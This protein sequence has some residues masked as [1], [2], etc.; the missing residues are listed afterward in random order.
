MSLLPNKDV[1]AYFTREQYLSMNRSFLNKYLRSEKNGVYKEYDEVYITVDGIELNMYVLSKTISFNE[2]EHIVRWRK[3][4]W[5]L[6][7]SK[8]QKEIK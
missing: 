4:N 2:H 6:A 7:K 1:Q 5:L 8:Y 3:S